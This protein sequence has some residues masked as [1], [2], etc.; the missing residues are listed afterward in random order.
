MTVFAARLAAVLL[1]GVSAAAQA[2][3]PGEAGAGFNPDEELDEEIVITGQKPRGSVIGDIQPE[4][5]LNAA[6]I[7]AYGVATIAELLDEL[8]AETRSDR[9]SGGAPVVLL[10]GK[11]ISGFSEIRDIPT[12]AIQR[13]EILPEEV[14]LKYGYRADQK[15]V[16]IV[17]RR[18]FRATTVEA[19]GRTSTDGGGTAVQLEGTRFQIRGDN[20]L[21]LSVEYRHAD[22]LRESQRD[23]VSRAVGAPFAAAGNVGAAGGGEIDPALSALAGEPV[24]IAG[25]TAGAAGGIPSLAD[26]VATAGIPHLDDVT[27]YRTLRPA[28]EQ[29][30]LN[31]V[32]SRTVLGNVSATVNASL[33]VTGSDSLNGLPGISVIVPAASPFSPFAD[34]VTLYRYP[35]G[36][37]PLRQRVRGVSGHA[38][39]ALSGMVADWT[40]SLTGNYDH[41]ESRT[42]SDAGLDA[43]ALQARLSAGDPTLNPY[44][45]LPDGLVAPRAA[46]RARGISDSGTL[47]LVVS[48]TLARLP[49]GAVTTTVKA[50]GAATGFESRSWR[51][52]I[53][54]AGSLSRETGSGQL[55]LDLPIASRRNQVLA[56]LGDLSV[57]F[58]A[59]VDQV[60]DFGTLT[61]IGYGANWS[62]TPAL[63]LIAS[64]TNDEAAPGMQQ[65]GNPVVL[66]PDVRVFDYIRGVTASVTQID[67]G[68]AALRATERRVIKLGA[69]L[70]PTDSLTLSANFISRRI[71]NPVAALPAPTA[72]IEA[73]FPDRFVRDAD[74]ILVQVDARPVNFARRSGSELRWGFNFSQRL[75]TSERVAEALRE[76][77]RERWAAMAAARNAAGQ[78][79]QG[80]GTQEPGA[81]GQRRGPGRGAGGPPGGGFGGRGGGGQAGGRLQLALYHTWHFRDDV[82]V[83]P[84][85][86]VLDLLGGDAVGGRGGQARHELE[87]RAGVSKDGY[88]LRLTG[89]WQSATRVSGGSS[90][91]LRFSDLATVNLRLFAN[92]GQIPSLARQRWAQGARVSLSVD[93]IFNARQTVRD[94]SGVVPISYQP[95]YLD[96]MGRTV[97]VNLRKLFF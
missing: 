13:T 42:V 21:N 3:Q 41:G 10:N 29:L 1:L 93:N 50:G 19:D 35:A 37:G 5:Q 45:V 74:G 38:G 28:S 34:D 25:V 53:A 36:F 82:L 48:G 86:P 39:V 31:A 77:A 96:P 90:G 73:A 46:N 30:S 44:G 23:L 2:A 55:N 95:G 79:P 58:N 83:R 20:R 47:E 84:G 18:R 6:D 80:Q 24:T 15:V 67:G 57:N 7:R 89:D 4:L 87:L 56:A 88:G 76:A 75:K 27:R 9:G 94:A 68:N 54:T 32:L 63:R 26:F 64:V 92:L 43:S 62:P 33:D 61:T 51:N 71:R 78:G 11:R 59:A 40:W 81:Q 17:L 12:E 49:A 16:N 60:S 65:L 52:G 66:T 97:R 22:P 85:L 72:E 70:K 69:N 14:A 8:S 91:T